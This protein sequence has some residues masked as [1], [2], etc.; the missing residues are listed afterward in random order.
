MT[1]LLVANAKIRMVQSETR[2]MEN[3]FWFW[4]F[5]KIGEEAMYIR[6]VIHIVRMMRGMV[7]RS[8]VHI[9]EAS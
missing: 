3:S 7:R 4:E 1:K 9:E 2:V 8:M 5:K 6:A